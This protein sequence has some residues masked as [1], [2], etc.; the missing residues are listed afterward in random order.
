MGLMTYNLGL[1]IKVLFIEI[2]N[3]TGIFAIAFQRV[4]LNNFHT[5]IICSRHYAINHN[6]KCFVLQII[7]VVL[8]IM[9]I[10]KL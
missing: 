7:E 6:R 3:A 1:C 4:L 8:C 10:I 9:K 5:P 2:F